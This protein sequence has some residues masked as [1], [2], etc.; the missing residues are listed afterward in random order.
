MKGKALSAAPGTIERDVSP[1]SVK[2][3]W[4]RST[5]PTNPLVL[6]VE[7]G[8]RTKGTDASRVRR[9]STVQKAARTGASNE[10][11]GPRTAA[12]TDGRAKEKQARTKKAKS[13]KTRTDA[14]QKLGHVAASMGQ[15]PIWSW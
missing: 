3:E 4:Q 8:I 6:D 13:G 1:S 7:S 9:S 5:Q 15:L 10:E 11:K 2:E 14:L 12:K